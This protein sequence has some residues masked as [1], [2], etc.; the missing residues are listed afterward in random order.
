[1]AKRRARRGDQQQSVRRKGGH[2]LGEHVVRGSRGRP[3]GKGEGAEI[4][5][6]LLRQR[7]YPEGLFISSP[8]TAALLRQALL[9]EAP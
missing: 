4:Y 5:D 8:E 9:A 1:M 7:R 6:D 3:F 2:D